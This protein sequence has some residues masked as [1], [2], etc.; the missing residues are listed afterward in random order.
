MLALIREVRAAIEQ[1]RAIRAVGDHCLGS[2]GCHIVCLARSADQV[3]HT[4]TVAHEHHRHAGLPAGGAPCGAGP[5]ELPAPG[6]EH[7]EPDEPD[8][9]D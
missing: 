9:H 4:M 8:R 2:G 6:A 3:S 1:P 7:G 5:S